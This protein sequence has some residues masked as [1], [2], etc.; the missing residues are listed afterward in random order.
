MLDGEVCRGAFA[1]S[2]LLGGVDVAVAFADVEDALHL[3]KGRYAIAVRAF[4]VAREAGVLEEAAE[5]GGAGDHDADVGGCGVAE[6]VQRHGCGVYGFA[7]DGKAPLKAVGTFGG[8][9]RG[10]FENDEG[11]LVGVAM[12]RHHYSRRNGGFKDTVAVACFGIGQSPLKFD[13]QEF[14]LLGL[15]HD[16]HVPS[17][18]SCLPRLLSVSAG[19]G[20]ARR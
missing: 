12:G 18:F 16:V 2:G 19:R 5:V 10:S 15:V 1:L 14:K 6:A 8:K 4:V 20:G 11:L 17:I 13:T 7:G 3:L 9:F